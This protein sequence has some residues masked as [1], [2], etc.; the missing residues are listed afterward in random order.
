MDCTGAEKF[1]QQ[2]GIPLV[3]QKY[4][5]T[6]ERWRSLQKMKQSEKHGDGGGRSNFIISDQDR[7]GTVGAVALDQAGNLAAATS[8]GGTTNKKVGRIGDSP[9]I[10]AG[11]FANNATCAVSATGDGEF[12]IRIVAAHDVSALIEYRGMSLADATQQVLDKVANLGGTGGLIAIDSHGN[13]AQPFN[14]S[15]MYRGSI[16]QTGKTSVAI[17]R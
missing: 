15:G 17:Y 4:F 16:D 6:E 9:V 2:M 14:S 12:F 7:H 3:D 10:G 11:T 1:A 8:T 13:I 5:Y